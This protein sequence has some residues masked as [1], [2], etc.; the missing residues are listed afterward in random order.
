MSLSGSDQAYTFALSGVARSGATRSDYIN[1]TAIISI[2]GIWTG[3]SA[4]R[5]VLIASLSIQDLLNE[6]P[7]TCAF[8][9]QGDRPMEGAEVVIQLG[10]KTAPR[11]FGGHI[12][13]VTEV[14]AAQ[15]PANVLWQVEGIDYTWRL[16][17]RLVNGRYTAMAGHDVAQDL[18]SRF[19]PSGFG[20][21]FRNALSDID[22]ISFTNVPF[23]EAM[24]QIA[25]RC[26]AQTYCDYGRAIVFWYADWFAGD[27]KPPP[28]PLT[29]EHSSLESVTFTRDLSQVVTR[30]IVEGGGVSAL[31][32]VGVG[33]TR[34][35]VEEITSWYLP[36]GGRVRTSQQRLTYS[37]LVAGGPGAL[38]GP[39]V[40]PTNAPIATPAPGAGLPVGTYHYAYTWLSAAGETLPSAAAAATVGSTGAPTGVCA[41]V[42][43]TGSGLSDGR[44]MYRVSFLIGANETLA[45]PASAYVTTSAM[46][47]P[48]ATPEIDWDTSGGGG[49]FGDV[50]YEVGIKYAYSDGFVRSGFSGTRTA[51]CQA[52]A[53]EPDIPA[54]IEVSFVHSTDPN[55]P[56]VE[57]YGY[58]AGPFGHDWGRIASVANV[59]GAGWDTVRIATAYWQPTT[60]QGLGK[61][62]VAIN[63]IPLGA[64]GTTGRKLYRTASGGT[65]Y[66]LVA[67]LNDNTSTQWHNDYTPDGSRGPAPLT[68][69]TAITQQI[70]VTGIAS[71]PSGTTGRNVYR[72]KVNAPTPRYLHTNIPNNSATTIPLDVRTDASLPATQPP[73]VDTS[74]LVSGGGVAPAGST[75]LRVTSTAPFGSEG[76]ARIGPQVI[77]YKG[78]TA[79]DLTNI[80]AS[81]PGSL[82]TAISF[83]TEVVLASQLIGIPAS[84]ANSIIYTVRQGDEVNVLVILDDVD[85]QTTLAALIGNDGVVEGTLVDN[86]ISDAEAR[87]RA[88]AYLVQKKDPVLTLRYRVRDP[89]TRSGATITVGLPPPLGIS[90]SFQIQDVRISGF[91]GT[92]V[93]PLY[94]ASASS[95]RFTFEDLLRQARMRQR[96]Q[97]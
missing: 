65:T 84:G 8:T 29:P 89:T 54:P 66:G 88:V 22:E 91:L 28:T 14:Y 43:V 95:S 12:L 97:P 78:A 87:S 21:Y 7:N 10:N 79:T 92:S 35:P 18:F 31:A 59:A 93:Y 39:G 53:G 75:S 9:V 81:G 4:S 58:Q 74:G 44:Y 30:A 15:N 47:P 32:D 46:P 83:G 23:M 77:R 42:V 2:G 60:P 72:S 80:P 96:T 61:Y 57:I 40:T 36:T 55:V 69:P 52:A 19:A 16:N 64:A 1:R 5:R 70:Q 48:F 82:T 34:I 56:T 26:G 3:A 11:I 63:S 41:P 68:T 27:A 67:T 85:A 94:E 71:G 90:G 20:L 73:T 24:T 51:I 17:A 6:T 13:R 38:V 86:R 62:G 33:D 25:V 49:N 37:G 50:G 45:G 76:W